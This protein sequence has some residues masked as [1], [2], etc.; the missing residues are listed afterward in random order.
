MMFGLKSTALNC[1]LY[2][3]VGVG[4]RFKL[5]CY[6]YEHLYTDSK[7]HLI[8]VLCFYGQFIFLW[9]YVC[10]FLAFDLHC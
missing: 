6:S 5:R 7:P 9:K 1:R 3:N 4:M 8:S 10:V 2:F